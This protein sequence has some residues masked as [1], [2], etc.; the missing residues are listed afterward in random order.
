VKKAW[1]IVIAVFLLGSAAAVVVGLKLV[2]SRGVVARVQMDGVERKDLTATV[3]APGRVRASAS[4]D[5]SAEVPGRIVEL[6]VEEGDSVAA[7]QTLLRLDDARY[8][9]AIDQNQAALRGA[10]ANLDLSKARLEKARLDLDRQERLVEQNLASTQAVEDARTTYKVYLA[11]VDAREQ[12]VASTEAALAVTRDD[13]EKTVYRAPLA[14]IISRLNVEAGE[15]VMVGTMNNPGTVLLSIADLSA[16]EVEADVDETDVVSVR[17]GQAATITVDALPDVKFPGHVA[18][19][20]NSGR[21]TGMGTSDQAVDFEVRVRFADPDPRLRPGMTA[22]VEIETETRTE[23]LS[24]PLQALIAR[25]ASVIERDRR[26]AAGEA[27]PPDSLEDDEDAGG[28]DVV[29]GVYKVVD[30][31]ALFAEVTT[32]ITDGARI[33]VTGD[34]EAGDRVVSGP[35]R[36]LRDLAEGTRL[37][38]TKRGAKDKE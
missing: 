6:A 13:L 31:K 2:R 24:V 25:S 18:T 35:Y 28:K 36:V 19:V 8:R 26:K 32:G 20:G 4:V 27:V 22:D 1:I 12:D 3:S 5:L 21:G 37:R 17:S 15:I 7:G 14:G 11:E 9:S 10:K 29:E 16:M 30:G 38:E 33:E 23:V 34:L